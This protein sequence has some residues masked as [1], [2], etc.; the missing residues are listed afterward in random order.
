MNNLIDFLLFLAGILSK[1]YISQRQHVTGTTISCY[2][3]SGNKLNAR[4]R[5]KGC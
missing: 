5:N 2:T 3:K 1:T 4:I